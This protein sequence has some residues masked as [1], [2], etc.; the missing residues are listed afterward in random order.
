M[1]PRHQ[2]MLGFTFGDEALLVTSHALLGIAFGVW[3]AKLGWILIR[4]LSGAG[5]NGTAAL[6][7]MT[8]YF[9]NLGFNAFDRLRG[10]FRFRGELG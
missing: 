2:S 1:M 10:T 6:I 9:I 7:M 8:G 5:R 4:L 3:A